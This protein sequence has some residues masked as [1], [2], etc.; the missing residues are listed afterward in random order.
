MGDVSS[1]LLVERQS[2]HLS[3]Y[4]LDDLKQLLLLDGIVGGS[5]VDLDEVELGTM[6]RKM[7]AMDNRLF[8]SSTHSF[9]LPSTSRFCLK[10][11]RRA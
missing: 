11:L 3:Q 5:N 6:G 10:V 4:G 7:S 9:P 1:S 2:A 8:G